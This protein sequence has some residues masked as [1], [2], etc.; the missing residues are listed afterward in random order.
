MNR[1]LNIG[2]VSVGHSALVNDEIK[3]NLS[4]HHTTTNVLYSFISNVD[5]KYIGKT[6]MKLSQRMYNY[7]NPGPS[8]STNEGFPLNSND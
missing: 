4:T 8:Q 5:V 7:Q 2:F 6:T 3:F 1:L